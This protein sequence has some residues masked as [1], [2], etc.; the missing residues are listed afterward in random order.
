MAQPQVANLGLVLYRDVVGP[1][2]RARLDWLGPVSLAV[3]AGLAATMAW[4]SLSV[5]G[6]RLALT[7]PR[8]YARLH[9][10]WWLPAALLLG[11]LGAMVYAPLTSDLLRSFRPWALPLGVHLSTVYE[12]LVGGVT[13]ALVGLGVGLR[14]SMRKKVHFGQHGSGYWARRADLR[15]AP[16]K[17]KKKAEWLWTLPVQ[18]HW[19]GS[20]KIWHSG[21]GKTVVTIPHEEVVRHVLL[22]GATGS[23]KGYTYFS[24]IIASLRQPFILQDVKSEC[25]GLDTLRAMTGLEPIRW[26]C[27]AQ[28][29][30][31][32]MRY[33]FLHAARNSEN[34]KE[35]CKV[36]AQAI[37]PTHGNQNDF[38]QTLAADTLAF[39]FQFSDAQTLAEI[40]DQIER[41][42]LIPLVTRLG[43]LPGLLGRLGGKNM[44]GWTVDAIQGGLSPYTTGW[45]REATSAHDFELDDLFRR[46]GYVLSG[47]PVSERA[48]PIR[49]FWQ[50]LLRQ[51]LTSN[52]AK[53][54]TLL[55]DEGL[56]A[57]KIPDFGKALQTLRSK[58]V[59]IHYGV[60][61][62]QGVLA[63]YGRE[64]GQTIL[65]NFV[66][67]VVLLNGLSDGDRKTLSLALGKQTLLEKDQ[68]GIGKA[69]RRQQVGADLLEV[70]DL[71]R[72]A[73]SGEFWAVIRAPKITKNGAPILCKLTG[74]AGAGLVRHPSPQEVE[75]A[76][77]AIAAM[78]QPARYVPPAPPTTEDPM[79]EN[80][81]PALLP[82][83]FPAGGKDVTAIVNSELSTSARVETETGESEFYPPEDLIFE[84]SEADEISEA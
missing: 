48:A 72:R 57:G 69:R 58:G 42:G 83:P 53:N 8:L 10:P 46:G 54:L 19:R 43:A 51:A 15:I 65:E 36:L 47:E 31:P 35:N 84:S 39:L 71:E 4:R 60:Q 82:E 59:S 77:A 45:A 75:A 29:G 20:G 17:S 61:N 24:P 74:S 27:A 18:V 21:A 56:A 37:C 40:S 50:L 49:V 52:A 41:E 23:G 6:Q 81:A 78:P 67:R 30:W 9:G 25:Q 66:S 70:A 26:G 32:S 13:V 44:D 68:A 63:L 14:R 5:T 28:G 16:A 80:P 12:T 55:F 11:G 1:I 73:M 62:A 76:R 3:A 64:E 79:P 38:I 7:R 2:Y 34:L 33:N 22:V